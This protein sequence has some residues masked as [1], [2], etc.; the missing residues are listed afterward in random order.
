L[1]SNFILNFKAIA[2]KFVIH[3]KI[4]RY[5]FICTGP[6]SSFHKEGSYQVSRAWLKGKSRSMDELFINIVGELYPAGFAKTAAGLHRHIHPSKDNL[7][8]NTLYQGRSIYKT[9]E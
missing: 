8:H 6:A 9:H 3:G 1:S 2:Y 4:R 7:C 5:D